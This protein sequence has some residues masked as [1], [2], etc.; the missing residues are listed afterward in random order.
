MGGGGGGDPY[1]E[2]RNKYD[3]KKDTNQVPSQHTYRK[4]CD[5]TMVVYSIIDPAHQSA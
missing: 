4:I 2:I 5:P 3:I 1:G